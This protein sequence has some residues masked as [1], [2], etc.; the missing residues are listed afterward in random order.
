MEPNIYPTIVYDIHPKIRE[1]IE[2]LDRGGQIDRDESNRPYVTKVEDAG[3]N[4]IVHIMRNGK[5]ENF[6]IATRRRVHDPV[7]SW[8]PTD[9]FVRPNKPE[10][11]K[12]GSARPERQRRSSMYES[13]V[14][15]ILGED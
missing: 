5:S 12:A 13:I 15:K 3:K 4:R 6:L 7:L 1:F 2:E 8:S 10:Q 9:G 14:D 11:T